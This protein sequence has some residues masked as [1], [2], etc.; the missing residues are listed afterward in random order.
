MAPAM[1]ATWPV[2]ALTRLAAAATASRSR[3]GG[4]RRRRLIADRLPANPAVPA[5][6]TIS[7]T[8]ARFAAPA[9]ARPAARVPAAAACLAAAVLS[10]G[11][12]RLRD[13]CPLVRLVLLF[14][15]ATGL[16]L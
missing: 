2:T 1:S 10:T 13:R 6:P 15:W 8:L 16:L 9:T 3:L 14:V 12:F 11:C 5:P 7:G 4:R